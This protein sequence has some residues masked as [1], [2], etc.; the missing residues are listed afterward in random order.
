M[1]E[2]WYLHTSDKISVEKILVK[3]SDD[4]EPG[5]VLAS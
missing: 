4:T 2:V 3:Q 1:M 5:I